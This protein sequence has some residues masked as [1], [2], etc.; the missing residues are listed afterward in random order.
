[1]S[2]EEFIEAELGMLH[3]VVTQYGPVSRFWFDGTY[4]FPNG[5]NVTDLW[6]RAANLLRQESP[7]TLWKGPHGGDMR[8]G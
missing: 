2:A 8:T 5:T 6:A 4:G 3:E 7:D 1:M